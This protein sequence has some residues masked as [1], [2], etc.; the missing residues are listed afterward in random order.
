[1][2]LAL[3]LPVWGAGTKPDAPVNAQ[4]SAFMVGVDAN[5]SLEMEEK[6][7][8]WKWDGKPGDVFAGTFRHGVRWQRIRLW[9]SNEG[10]NGRDYATKLV[11]RSQAVGLIPYLTIFLSD[12]W[13]DLN[14]Q[15]APALW[16][17]LPLPQRAAAVQK[18]SRDTV[19]HFRQQ[20][21][22]SHLYEI[23]NEIDYGICGVY[24]VQGEGIDPASLRQRAWPQAVKLIL[25]CQQGVKAADPH[26]T[27]MLHIAHWW[28][29]GFCTSFFR[30][31]LDSGV[32]LDYAGLSY[33]PSANIG[34]SLT[35]QQF[36][37]VVGTLHT[38]IHCPVIVAET[39]YP[40]A[41]DFSGQF[42]AWRTEVPG[43]PLTPQGQL[44]WLRDFL[45]FCANDSRIAGVFYWSPEW[46][47]EGP[48]KAFALFDNGGEVRPAWRAFG[49]YSH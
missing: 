12:D 30:Y 7:A 18:Y 44:D 39:A 19:L 22:Q 42:A 43:Y 47:G 36:G 33:Y 11:Q 20:G 10:P 32:Q 27:F 28:D 48:W 5:Y 9:T 14:K 23:G 25:A 3:R 40:S 1:M 34:G 13:T 46:Y 37:A 31:M 2:M 41:S 35:F 45:R 16:R 8:Q 49:D 21:L 24:P 4:K 6:G 26:A 29:A 17:D 38:A 15:P